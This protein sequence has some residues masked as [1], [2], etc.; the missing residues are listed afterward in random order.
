MDEEQIEFNHTMHAY[1]TKN[2]YYNIEEFLNIID[3]IYTNISYA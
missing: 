2:I 1:Y 3:Y